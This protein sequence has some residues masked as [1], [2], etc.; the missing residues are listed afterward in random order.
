MLGIVNEDINLKNRITGDKNNIKIS[1]DYTNLNNSFSNNTNNIDTDNIDTD[2]INT[3]NIDII[4]NVDVINSGEKSPSIGSIDN[5]E[6]ENIKKFINYDNSS[7]SLKEQFNNIIGCIQ[8]ESN[9]NNCHNTVLT[10]N[11]IVSN[12]TASTNI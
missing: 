12:N 5:V 7:L 10:Q 4:Q 6:E 9:D 11:I 8:T 1:K 2:N 3:D